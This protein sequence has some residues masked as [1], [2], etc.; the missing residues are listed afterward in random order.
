MELT[1]WVERVQSSSVI[2]VPL[3]LGSLAPFS[4]GAGSIC[5]TKLIGPIVPELGA[6]WGG[7]GAELPWEWRV[8]KALM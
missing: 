8:S 1:T 2:K 6:K 7:G 5:F 4:L 3:F